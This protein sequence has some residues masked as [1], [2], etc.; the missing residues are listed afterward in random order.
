M[1]ELL[2]KIYS[3]SLGRKVDLSPIKEIRKNLIGDKRAVPGKPGKRGYL[4]YFWVKWQYGDRLLRVAKLT[5][6]LPERC[7]LCGRFIWEHPDYS[8]QNICDCGSEPD[9]LV[10]RPDNDSVFL[11]KNKM[12]DTD[13]ELR[14]EQMRELY[15]R[16]GLPVRDLNKMFDVSTMTVFKAV[17]Y[18]R[19][20]GAKTNDFWQGR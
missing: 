15:L 13:R 11:Y 2:Q 4:N 9:N 7:N 6:V 1:T 18:R 5:A 19:V 10:R 14:Q 8:T 3:K 17:T 12:Y 20:G 16:K